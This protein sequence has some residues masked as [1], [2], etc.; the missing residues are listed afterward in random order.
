MYLGRIGDVSP[1]DISSND[2]FSLHPDPNHNP[3]PNLNRNLSP[4]PNTD[5]KPNL[6]VAVTCL[7]IKGRE[8]KFRDVNCPVPLGSACEL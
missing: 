5:P 7:E 8:L 2:T 6:P 3:N 4:N 1:H